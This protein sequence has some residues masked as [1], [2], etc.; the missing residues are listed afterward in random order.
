MY[1]IIENTPVY[2]GYLM[3]RGN[4][5]TH[6]INKLLTLKKRF[7]DQTPRF[8][9]TSEMIID[10]ETGYSLT[11]DSEQP[12]PLFEPLKRMNVNTYWVSDGNGYYVGIVLDDIFYEKVKDINQLKDVKEKKLRNIKLFHKDGEI[13]ALSYRCVSDHA[14][15]WSRHSSSGPE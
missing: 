8:N 10:D 7:Q 15:L 12:C 5:M 9:G 1:N 4:E 11:P 3:L 6:I 14:F 13:K 2:N